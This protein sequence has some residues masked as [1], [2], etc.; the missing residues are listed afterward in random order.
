MAKSITSQNQIPSSIEG[1]EESIK[2]Y[3]NKI[4]HIDDFV[5]ACRRFPG[6]YLGSVRDRGWKAA[7]REIFQNAVDEEIRKESPCHYVKITF[8]E[9][10]RAI[11]KGQS[12]VLY[13]GDVVLGG[14]CI[15]ETGILQTY[16]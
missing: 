16:N 5:T 13:D 2:N 12:V 9:P 3:G 11:T 6:M 8:D 15:I 7:I 4:E 14:G 1:Y 10:I